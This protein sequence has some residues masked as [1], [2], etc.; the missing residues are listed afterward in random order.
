L[1][2][3]N[4]KMREALC[5]RKRIVMVVEVGVFC[6]AGKDQPQQPKAASQVG[7]KTGMRSRET[8]VICGYSTIF[9]N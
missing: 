6:E 5:G 4:A 3:A 1:E 8:R 7:S 9:E 2:L